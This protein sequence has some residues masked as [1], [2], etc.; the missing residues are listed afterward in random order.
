VT[1]SQTEKDPSDVL[2]Y[3]IDWSDTLTESSPVDTISSSTWTATSGV[4]VGASSIAG[5]T[6]TV[7]VSAGTPWKYCELTN[8]I[9]TDGSRTHSKTIV[10]RLI[11][12]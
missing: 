4:V 7:M 3:S 9:V 1:I 6:T 2:D 11:Q 8:V 5:S 12:K 10:L